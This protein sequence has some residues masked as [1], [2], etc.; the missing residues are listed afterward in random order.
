M[1]NEKSVGVIIIKSLIFCQDIFPVLIGLSIL[2]IYHW[3]GQSQINSPQMDSGE[4]DEEDLT[5]QGYSPHI[6]NNDMKSQISTYRGVNIDVESLKRSL[7][8]RSTSRLAGNITPLKK[9]F[10]VNFNESS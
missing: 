8:L 1:R 10:Q 5:I 6:S 2:W 7:N 3:F 9:N 4:S